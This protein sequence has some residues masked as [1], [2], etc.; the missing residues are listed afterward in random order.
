MPV[1]FFEIELVK[2]RERFNQTFGMLTV[3]DLK[4]RQQAIL[5][6]CFLDRLKDKIKEKEDKDLVRDKIKKFVRA[7][8]VLNK[9]FDMVE[10]HLKERSHHGDTANGKRESSSTG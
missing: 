6:I 2:A 5:A 3:C 9:T 4:L 10:A 7:R 1:D 8:D